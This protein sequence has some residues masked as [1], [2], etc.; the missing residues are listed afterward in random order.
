M[1]GRSLKATP[2]GIEKASIALTDRAW[3]R[4][5]LAKDVCDRQTA[6]KFFSGKPIDRKIFVQICQKLDLDWQEIVGI[7]TIAPEAKESEANEADDIDVLVEQA[8]SQIQPYIKEKCGSMRV[9]D[10]TQ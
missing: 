5:D 7:A 8:R 2:A 3:S 9:L 6:M 4:E 10:M 1:V